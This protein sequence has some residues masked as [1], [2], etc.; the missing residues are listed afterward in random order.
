MQI[1]LIRQ[2]EISKTTLPLKVSGQHRIS[3]AING[4]MKPVV[5][6]SADN[7][8]WVIRENKKVEVLDKYEK[9]FLGAKELRIKENEF[10]PIKYKASGEKMILLVEP[11][12]EGRS[13]F[14]FF[15]TP[16][17]GVIRIGYE[18]TNHI[19]FCDHQLSDTVRA[20]IQYLPDGRITVKDN[21]SDNGVYLNNKRL[22]EAQ[23]RC[24]DELYLVG[25][26]IILGKGFV[27]V[28]N[29]GNS[30]T[31]SLAKRE[32]D[33]F[34]LADDEKELD[35]DE[36]E[37]F[38][39]APKNKNSMFKREKISIESPPK[40]S[41]DQ[42][43]PMALVMGPSITM[44]FGSLFSSVFTILN[45]LNSDVPV[46]N[47]LPTAIMAICMVLGTIIWPV[48]SKRVEK[49]YQVLRDNKKKRKYAEH[50][51]KVK[52]RIE[53][54]IEKQTRLLI[55]NNPTVKD[56]ISRINNKEMT[57]WE[58]SPAHDDFLNVMVGIGDVPAE[59][60]LEYS[61]QSELEE[62]HESVQALER[63]VDSERVL[64]K[65]P[66]TIP[67]AKTK[68]TGITG[69]RSEIISATKAML[70]ELTALHNYEDLKIMFIYNE[71]ERR[72]WE[73]VKWIPHVWN[74][75][76]TFR[77][78]AND[79]DEAKELSNVISGILAVS[80][81]DRSEKTHDTHYLIIAAD[82]VLAEKIQG[83]KDFLKEP[84]KYNN[85]SVM[86]LYDEQR[87]LPKSCSV[88]CN[89]ES[90]GSTIADYNNFNGEFQNIDETVRYDGNP[91]Q[92]F[93]NMANIE[94][95]TLSK[96]SSLPTELTYLEMFEA[97]KPE[98]L[99]ILSHWEENDPVK[100]LSAPIGVD[101]DGYTIKLD[102]HE[103]AHGPHGLIAGMTGS[104]KSEF[105]IA[106]I[107]SMAVNYS[108][109][110]VAFVLIDFKGGGMADVFKKLPHLAGS[111]TN[112]DGNEIQRSF[113]AI[114]SELEKRQALF[115][116]ISEKKKISNIDIYKYQKLRKED[117]SLKP[118]P[119]LIIISDEF[120]EL[121]QQHSDFMDQ[122]I[123]IARIGRSLGV[124]LILATQKPDGVVNEQIKSNIKFKICL[125]VQDKADSQ[126]VIN[127]PDATMITNAGRFYME[128]GF[129]EIFEYGQSPWSGAPYFPVD[130]YRPVV[131]KNIDILN[132]QGR[133]I[134]RVKPKDPPRPAGVPEK[135][136]DALVEYIEAIAAEKGC[137]AEKIWLEPMKGPEK[138]SSKVK[139][140]SDEAVPFV[141]NPVV[142]QYDD[143]KN[144]K[145][146]TLTVPLTEEGNAIVYG[147][148][149]SGKLS[150]I[151]QLMVSL[152]ER[153]T[154]EEV[155]I[156]ALDY[157]SGSL[158]AFDKA[159]HVKT[160]AL[161]DDFRQVEA[162]FEE[163]DAELEARKKIFRKF[164]GDYQNY[165][166]TSGETVPNI[167]LIIHNFLAFAES[168]GDAEEKI[169]KIAREGKKYGIFVVVTAMNSNS[170]RYSLVPM[171]SNV[172]V[173]RQNN[174]D[175]Y[176]NI[177]G[178]TGGLTPGNFKGRGI[179]KLDNTV[180]EFQTKIAF[181]DSKNIYDA[182]EKFCEN[183]AAN[184]SYKKEEKVVREMPEKIAK[185]YFREQGIESAINCLPV[186][187]DAVTVDPICMDMSSAVLTFIM[188]DDNSKDNAE[189]ICKAVV[190]AEE[191]C[192][193]IDPQFRNCGKG[194][195]AN[196]E[197]IEEFISIL[198][199]MIRKRGE[200]GVREKNLGNP[201]PD[202]E[203]M[204]VLV[205]DY[206]DLAKIISKDSFVQLS[207]YM[208]NISLSFHVHFIIT[209]KN[210]NVPHI[211]SYMRAGMPVT[212]G[213]DFTNDTQN[214]EIFGKNFSK[215]CEK[216][217]AHIVIKG[218]EHIGKVLINEEEGE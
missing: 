163:I 152:I 175:Q 66:I 118:L 184:S 185:A 207:G 133:T 78:I 20:V 140:F 109:E 211:M 85:I 90:T 25:L 56:C 30:V 145:H 202:F 35:T 196:A 148:S 193:V 77:Y 183:V 94:L 132:E 188:Y 93:V 99:D 67:L 116:E 149:G 142:G 181:E 147:V 83:L 50:L 161:S 84:S 182:I 106:Y 178:R 169:S 12:G 37:T 22:T 51:E 138:D 80:E 58:R 192:I 125:K 52:G 176:V 81:N 75:E 108:P 139:A 62:M 137:A 104:G 105:I 187:V 144:R 68:I 212:Q 57:L 143:L 95:D 53:K 74:K 16:S 165:I 91:E 21:G 167:V 23:A 127:R 150:F 177:L 76:K 87:R 38:S 28:N 191:K 101:A 26:R 42:K 164:G 135:Q 156:Y 27:A 199:E 168:I 195:I 214:F 204:Y 136:I 3:C 194:R 86:A 33:P 103:K 110:E 130:Q 159:P 166:R 34:K 92:I 146:C 209:D 115:K 89:I 19:C 117:K 155:N 171:F 82:R 8:R 160:V 170:I 210:G 201:I 190:E 141:L 55:E 217:F 97:G 215:S 69:K 114:E 174:E 40:P 15:K 218:V 54:T 121:K 129:N 100:S 154:P 205:K 216:G 2:N 63:L 96:E 32:D 173:L 179:F 59:I 18:K 31:V 151:N 24:G 36:T 206:S 153:H 79:V 189:T 198:C 5:A 9:D 39:S 120:A 45:M 65:V 46:T 47:A 208:S 213:I 126:S 4:E 43:L 157:D 73:F 119:H 186:A 29:P 48:V 111:M 131:G 203:H 128:V 13:D 71:K 44:A 124:H 11:I 200:E 10:Y 7:G 172:Y 158:T 102:I 98:H 113:I 180:Y 60:D 6:V 1:V 134:Y 64:K 49:R 107:A 123:R 162:A 41:E 70:I 197:K 122:L 61:K 72:C 17:D 112:L 14:S 88:V